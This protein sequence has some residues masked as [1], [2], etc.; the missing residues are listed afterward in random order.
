[1]ACLALRE[2]PDAGPGAGNGGKYG[3]LGRFVDL[4]TLP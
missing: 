1:V 3:W 2:P 4:V